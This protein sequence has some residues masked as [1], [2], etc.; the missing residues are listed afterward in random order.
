[1]D[2]HHTISVLVLFGLCGFAEGQV[3]ELDA[4]EIYELALP[5]MCA[6]LAL[7]D[8]GRE[9][10][11]GSGFVWSENRVVT[12]RHVIAGAAHVRLECNGEQATAKRVSQYS[13]SI[14][15]V[16]LEATLTESRALKVRDSN[17]KPGE[18]VFA[19]GNPFGLTNT[20]TTGIIGGHRDFHG[21]E[22]LQLSADIN[23]GNSGGPVLDDSGMLVAVATMGLKETQGLNFAL[24]VRYIAEL[25]SANLS[26][27]EV[28]IR[29]NQ[30]WES[31]QIVSDLSFRGV[32]LGSS[33]KSVLELDH[34][35]TW[36][37][38]NDDAPLFS[39]FTGAI[40]GETTLLGRPVVVNYRCRYGSL[41]SGNYAL[42]P[43]SIVGLV[44]EGL[45]EKYGPPNGRLTNSRTTKTGSYE[46]SKHWELGN[47]Q[48]IY[49][50]SLG[51]TAALYYSDTE[52]ERMLDRKEVLRAIPS[53]EL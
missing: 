14:D 18:S 3:A 34:S 37:Y 38:D 4:T 28:P 20:I 12:N 50:M 30:L 32:P 5:S 21:V 42:I 41:L 52:L 24:P 10:G 1:M 53:D 49:L 8:Q 31:T 9:L 48:E 2:R 17:V 40:G 13:E 6:V 43:S 46:L 25:P 35:T 45:A 44:D 51:G 19:I 26:L 11:F 47:G 15:L 27:S 7:S 29:E 23:P 33:C 16:V 22:Y 39:R 36:R